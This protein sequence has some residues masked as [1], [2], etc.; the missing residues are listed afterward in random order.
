L[1]HRSGAA[2]HPHARVRLRRPPVL[3]EHLDRG[4]VHLQHVE[5]KAQ[6]AKEMSARQVRQA[7]KKKS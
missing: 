3:L 6:V 4:L 7:M 2:P 5:A 1:R